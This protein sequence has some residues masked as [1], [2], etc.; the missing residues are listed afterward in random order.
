L[1]HRPAAAVEATARMLALR[2]AARREPPRALGVVGG[3]AASR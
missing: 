2:E 3:Q 1:A